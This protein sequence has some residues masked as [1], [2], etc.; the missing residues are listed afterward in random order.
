[1]N[2]IADCI[3]SNKIPCY[4]ISPHLDDAIL[5]CGGLI[6]LLAG[7]TKVS[8]ITLFT[9][10]DSQ[11]PTISAQAYLKQCG[12]NSA[13]ELFERRRAE[14]RAIMEKIGVRWLHLGFIDA[15]WRKKKTGLLTEM[16]GKII[17]EFIHIYP[18]YRY[19][20]MSGKQSAADKNLIIK[21]QQR[22]VSLK[23]T[24][25]GAVFFFPSGCGNHVDHLLTY[26]LGLSFAGKSFFYADF[27]YSTTAKPQLA[28]NLVNYNI[29]KYDH[30]LSDKADLID[31]YRSQPLFSGPPPREAETYYL[32]KK[33]NF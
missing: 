2:L 25:Q 6:T 33:I 32:N 31:Q 23:R 4:F 21:I 18:T 29:Y 9:E 12:F 3:I 11:S 10:A 20:I 19:H 16:L 24:E 1:M 13:Q 14:D 17:P 5:S 8:V 26:K 15:L 30:Y 28:D 27:P 22:L 7:K